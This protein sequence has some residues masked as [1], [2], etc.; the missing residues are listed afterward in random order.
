M[1]DNQ[2]KLFLAVSELGSFKQVADQQQISQ[3][4]V[5]KAM[6]RLEE[7]VG[8]PLF[9]RQANKVTLTAAGRFFQQRGQSLLTLLTDTR[10]QLHR[11]Q[12]QTKAALKIGYFSPFD[13]LILRRAIYQ[14]GNQIDF[15]VSEESPEHLISDVLI[16]NLDAALVMDNFGFAHDFAGMGLAALPLREDEIVIGVSQDFHLTGA[17]PM[18]LLKTM[19]I[20]YYSNEESTYLKRAFTGSLYHELTDFNLH[21]VL[22]YEQMQ[23]LVASG[24]ALS[25]Y[26]LGQ[27]DRDAQ[28]N[29][30]IDFLPIA[31]VERQQTIFK[32]IYRPGQLP[33]A[34]GQLI[35]F[36]KEHK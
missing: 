27:V 22:S 33:A 13:S 32:L 1:T 29:A 4:A 20:I 6:K 30:H 26:P 25:F 2:L 23:L 7:E 18:T 21:R 34:L 24:Q 28:V 36:F 12:H 31:G 9:H 5:S 16:G 17:V 15:L 3:R 35:A 8:V 14:L 10:H 11:F 19:P